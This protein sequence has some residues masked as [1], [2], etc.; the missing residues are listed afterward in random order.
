[1]FNR[2]AVT[3]FAVA[4][5]VCSC[6]SSK[7]GREVSKKQARETLEKIVKAAQESPPSLC[8]EL[9]FNQDACREELRVSRAGCLSADP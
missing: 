8:S 2:A 5:V 9:S 7:A 6:S 4:L 3:L 1:M